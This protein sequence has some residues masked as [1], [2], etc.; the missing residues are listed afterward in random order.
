MEERLNFLNKTIKAKEKALKRAPEGSLHISRDKYGKAKEKTR[1]Q[2]YHYTDADKK[3][4]TFIKAGKRA[5]AERLAQKD[6]DQ[7]IL[8]SATQEEKALARCLKQYPEQLVEEVFDKLPEVRKELVVPIKETDESFIQKWQGAVYAGKEFT[9]DAPEFYSDRGE[10]VRSK[11][12]MIIANLLNRENIPYRYEYPHCLEGN[13]L[14][15]TDFTILNVRDRKE[16]LWEHFGMMDDPGYVQTTIRKI[17]AYQ[18]SGFYPGENLIL[19]WECISQPI[20]V[21]LI[22]ELIHRYCL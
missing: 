22:K 5:L 13:Y 12:E 4:G 1:T 2:F 3:T 16:I 6:Y 21:K 9:E 18:L 14:V 19:T 8:R 7:R 15:Y 20:N 10:R 17:T 11:T